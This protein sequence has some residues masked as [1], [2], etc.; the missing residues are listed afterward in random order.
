VTAK[1]PIG[2]GDAPLAGSVST[3]PVGT[4][5]AMQEGT[6]MGERESIEGS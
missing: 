2:A 3:V 1:S 6:G 5:A 4:A